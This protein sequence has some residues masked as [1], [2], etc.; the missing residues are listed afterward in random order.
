[1]SGLPAIRDGRLTDRRLIDEGRLARALRALDG[2]GEET[3]LIG[4]AVRDL[5][6]GEKAGDYDLATTAL[7]QV[8]MKRAHA[9]GFGVAPTGLAHEIGRAHV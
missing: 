9:A 6:L 8:V 1:M 3:R 2:Q 7:P 4:G 5:A